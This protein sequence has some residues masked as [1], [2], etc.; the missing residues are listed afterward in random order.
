VE[1]WG[2]DL[3]EEWSA[4]KHGDAPAVHH[5]VARAM[6]KVKMGQSALNYLERAMEGELSPGVEEW[7][8]LYAQSH[9]L[10]CQLWGGVLGI[11]HRLDFMLGPNTS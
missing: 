7:H 4:M 9:Q 2:E 8:D 3:S 11:Q 1:R 6:Q 10:A 5:W